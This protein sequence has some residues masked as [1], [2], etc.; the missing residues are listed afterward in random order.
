MVSEPEKGLPGNQ[1]TSLLEDHAGRLWVGSDNSL[2]VYASGKFTSI[3]RK[4]G[5]A[6][7]L[8]M[9]LAEDSDHNLWVESRG[10]PATLILI[11]DMKVR[12]ELPAPPMPIAR[13]LAVICK[14]ESGWVW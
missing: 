13:K 14:A 2:W 11:Q 7:G 1:V 4:D 6:F 12:E 10:P 9:G 3:K 5:R 8:V